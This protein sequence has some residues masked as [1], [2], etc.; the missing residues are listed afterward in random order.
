MITGFWKGG[1]QEDNLVHFVPPQAD[2]QAIPIRK[3]GVYSEGK[4]LPDDISKEK[5]FLLNWLQTPEV[6]DAHEIVVPEGRKD[7]SRSVK[8]AEIHTLSEENAQL[9]F[10]EQETYAPRQAG[11]E[12]TS[13]LNGAVGN[14]TQ[15]AQALA[16]GLEVI[17]AK[18]K[19]PEWPKDGGDKCYSLTED[20]DSTN[21]DQ[22]SSE[23]RDSISSKSASFISLTESTV[24][25]Q[26]R[27]SK[28]RVPSGDG[29][30]PSA[31][32]RK[33]VKWD[34]S[35]TNLMSTAEVYSLEVQDNAEKRGDV[36]WFFNIGARHTDSEMLQSIYDSIKELQTETRA[37][38]RWAR[39]AAEHLQGT[40]RKV[41]KS[42]AEVEGK[43][44]SMEERTLAVEADIEALRALHMM[45]N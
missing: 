21:S 4:M 29:V 22:G 25:Q 28:G 6:L 33:A 11:Q 39:M 42:C 15:M 1:A 40:V 10:K 8:D 44:S 24:R 34:Y 30:E 31:Q 16:A 7:S 5:D 9:G 38:S 27:K 19:G 14:L 3:L 41:V 36:A 17:G 20:S 35:G 23:S 45:D 12:A 2:M 37:E 32:T 13:T 26:Q 43:L 18:E